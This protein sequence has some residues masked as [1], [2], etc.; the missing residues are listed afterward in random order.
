MRYKKY[1]LLELLFLFLLRS[2]LRVL[3]STN[4]LQQLPERHPPNISINLSP[5][6][7]KKIGSGAY[8]P[9]NFRYHSF[10]N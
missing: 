9:L 4:G 3:K 10:K 1:K 5:R 6:Q 2:F 7:P 8:F